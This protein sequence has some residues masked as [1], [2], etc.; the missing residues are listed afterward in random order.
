MSI[1]TEKNVGKIFVP[2][3]G[4]LLL[5]RP[6]WALSGSLKILL[7]PTVVMIQ[8]IYFIMYPSVKFCITLFFSREKK[9]PFR[10]WQTNGSPH[11]PFIHNFQCIMKIAS[12]LSYPNYTV[13]NVDPTLSYHPNCTVY[14]YLGVVV[15]Q[16][17]LSISVL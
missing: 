9:S 3:L 4:H 2:T 7:Q 15:Y 5:T 16:R 10:F 12:T 1:N 14:M 8:G 6:P 17:T 13:Y 11:L